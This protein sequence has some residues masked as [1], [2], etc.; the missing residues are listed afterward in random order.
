[1]T[2]KSMVESD[3]AENMGQFLYHQDPEINKE[4]W[5]TKIKNNKQ[6]SSS[7]TKLASIITCC[8]NINSSIYI[9]IYIYILKHMYSVL[10]ISTL[11][12][13]SLK[14][15]DEFTYLESRVSSTENDINTRLAKLSAIDTLSVI[16]KSDLFDKIKRK[17]NY[18]SKQLLC[19][20]H[21]MDAPYIR[22]RSTWRKSLMAIAQ[23]LYKPYCFLE[24]TSNK[25]ADIRSP[26]SH[27]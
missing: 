25:T 12:G 23:E 15:V 1:M 22:W 16:W 17:E 20:Y 11:T 14:L 13:H 9:Y 5:K 3:G 24:V 6:C 4:T 8:L 27:L 10:S 21:Y 19:Q 2:T 26:T 7:L 18:F